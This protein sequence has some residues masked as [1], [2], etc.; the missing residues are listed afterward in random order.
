VALV[1]E[2][3][4]PHMGGICEHVH[5]LARELRRRG[6][7]ADIVTSTIGNCPQDDGVIRIGRSVP[8]YANGSFARFTVGLALK[9]QLREV[10]TRGGYDVVHVH[11][12]LSPVL[13]M[14][15]TSVASCPVVGTVHTYFPS[16]FTYRLMHPVFQRSLDRLSAVIAVSKTAMD[17]HARYFNADW[18]IIPNGVDLTRFCP[19]VSRPD[20]ISPTADH[21]LF[22]GRLDPRNGLALLIASFRQ[23]RDRRRAA[24]TRRPVRLVIVGDGPLR[25]YYE[26]MAAGDPDILFIGA[27]LDGRESFYAHSDVYACPT[28]K[29]SFGITLLEAMAT[30]TPIVCSDIVG[31]RDVVR[32]DVEAVMAPCGDVG[33]FAMAIERV[34]DDPSLAA[35][36]ASAGRDNVEQYGWP[37]VTDQVLAVYNRVTSSVRRRA[38][39]V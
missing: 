6:H 22:L 25:Q 17:A 2:Y 30:A 11:S 5:F 14:L 23:I 15:A 26:R 16:S 29:A 20:A 18:H 1:T 7:H 19:D 13:P 8:A 3:Y 37:A 27:V 35:R 33:A 32:S 12:P 4:Y 10:L 9:R 21:V 24:G 38:S 36:L 39:R 28:T 31:F 34:F